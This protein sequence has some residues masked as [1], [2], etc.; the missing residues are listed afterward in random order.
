MGVKIFELLPSKTI[1]LKNL[2]GKIVLLD[3]SLV[4]YQFLSTIRQRDGTPLKDSHGNITSHLVGLFS[5]TTRLMQNNIKI[6]YVFDG[7]APDL[8]KKE[9]ERRAGLKKEAEIKYKKALASK[10]IESMQKYASRTSRLSSDMVEEAK[11][12]ISALGLP[13][14]QAPSEAEAQAADM[15]RNNKAFALGTQDADSFMFGCPKVIKNLAISGRRKKP[16]KLSYSSVKPEIIELTES[17]N[18]LGIDRE[19][20]IA[21]GMQIGTDFNIG[22]IKGIGPKNALKNV[23]KYGKDFDTMFK[24]LKWQDNFDYPWTEVYYTIKNM[25]VSE[26][27]TLKW[28]NL[29]E[30]GIFKILGERHD[31]SE[32][33]I[34]STL[35]KLQKNK[36]KKQQHS[37]NKWF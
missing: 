34:S 17:L 1:E 27:Y 37:L 21:L 28:N 2:S 35:E 33:R 5:R 26:D 22:G 10:D 3:A 12:L 11:E 9:R 6:A 31:F 18:K 15:V 16:G 29:D 36:K 23:K 20:L 19:Q 13:V 25:P 32:Q 24:E 30:S 4:L 8:K 7:K 14:I